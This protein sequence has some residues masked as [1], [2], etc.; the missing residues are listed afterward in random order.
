MK[1]KK[2]IQ[3]KIVLLL[4]LGIMVSIIIEPTASI[5]AQSTVQNPGIF[6]NEV[7][8]WNPYN[9]DPATNFVTQGN[10]IIQLVYE[11]LLRYTS[12]SL[13]SLT[14]SLAYTNYTV[15]PDGLTYSFTIKS[16]ITFSLQAGETVGQPFNA[17]VMQYSMQRAILM[18]DP[19]GGCPYTIDPFIVGASDIM[20]NGSSTYQ[21]AFLASQSIHATDANHLTITINKNFLGFIQALQFTATSAVSPKAII[22]NEPVSYT[23]NTIDATFGMI[24][25]AKF[26]PGMTNATILANLGLPSNYDVANSGVVPNAPANV[27]ASNEYTWTNTNSAGTGPYIVSANTLNIGGSLV[28]NTNWWNFASRPTSNRISTVIWKQ[29]AG[30]STRITDLS[31]GS[32]D[33]IGAPYSSLS[34]IIDINTL[35]P[36]YP[37]LQV[38]QYD[39]ITNDFIGFNMFPGSKTTMIQNSSSTYSAIGGGSADNYAN[40]K[41]YTWNNATG[42]PQMAD[43][44][45]PF[46]ALLFREAFGYAYDYGTYIQNIFSGFAI[47]MQGAIPKGLLGAQQDLIANGYIPSYDPVTAKALF[48]QV[49]WQGT[50][51]LYYN[52]GS[53]TRAESANL[54]KST[55]EGLNVGITINVQS[56]SWAQYLTYA[57][58]GSAPLWQL[59]WAP[60]YADA[61]DYTVPIYAN[62]TDGGFF[63]SI[64]NYNNPYVSSYVS[65]GAVATTVVAR[66][67]IYTQ[68]EHNATQDYPYIYIDQPQSFLVTRDW[69]NG[70]NDPTTNSLSGIQQYPSYQWLTKA[71]STSSTTSTTT[72]TTTTTTP[73]VT[74]TTG[75]V[76][77]TTSSQTVTTSSSSPDNISTDSSL[78]SSSSAP[79]STNSLISTSP[80]FELIAFIGIIAVSLIKVRRYRKKN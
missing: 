9:L 60:D 16:G 29:I 45:N 76:T 25:L 68:M 46:T 36:L 50:I 53:T 54:L 77:S 72:T 80:G 27:G 20:N 37:G 5:S 2:N 8:T 41:M 3:K 57:F 61:N 63:T 43:A 17:Y 42:Q 78:S 35:Q 75:T 38:N 31:S 6:V 47:R 1:S 70:L 30:V 48:Q 65:A 69:I 64:G 62:A 33:S 49:G 32:T 74:T 73:P 12:N 21:D 22:D 66:N 40:L 58:G 10:G 7:E 15:S 28:E 79:S 26:F 19:Q 56:V 39:T 67:A 44:Y 23:T 24:S 4:A 18:N 14:D 59:G 11:G 55:I 34:Q 51:T 52:S 71:G 13:N